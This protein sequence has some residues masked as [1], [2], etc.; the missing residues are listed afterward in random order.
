MKI[1]IPLEIMTGEARVPLTPEACRM[2]VDAGHSVF[3]QQDAGSNSGYSDQEYRL[4]GAQIAASSQALYEAA[5]LIIKVKQP[6]DQDI[7]SLRSDHILFSYLHLAADAALVKIL[8]DIGLTAIPFES[9]VDEGGHLPLLTPMSQVAGR[10]A[11]IR[12][13]SLLFRN[14]GG[15][16]ILLGGIDGAEAGRVVVLGAGVAGSHA[17]ASAVALGA[18]VDVVDLNENKLQLLK[19]QYPGIETHLSS[20]KVIE[21]LCLDAD[22][23]VGAVLIAG[24]RAPV[25]LSQSV[26]R[27]MKQGSV[28]VDISI[29]QG[30]CVESIKATSSESLCYTEHGVIHSAVPNMPATV[31]RTS[32]QSLSSAIL[33]YVLK[34]AGSELNVM[35]DSGSAMER[36]LYKAMAVQSGSIV[37]SVLQ[38]EINRH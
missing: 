32:S 35:A 16:G 20:G 18:R 31:A 5:Q 10:I 36:A 29:D 24:R 14:R 17:L 4:I 19:N 33:P 34:L 11:A 15:R 37:D 12:G 28:I 30:G 26:I 27:R 13:A 7:A 6:L 9:V 38:E 3:I 1:G 2:L 8:C 25:V 22:L 21:Q 23:V